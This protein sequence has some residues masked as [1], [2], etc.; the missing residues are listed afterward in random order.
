VGAFPPRRTCCR[1]YPDGGPSRFPFSD[2]QT[3]ARRLVINSVAPNTKR[4][5]STG[6]ASFQSFRVNYGL[7]ETW[8]PPVQDLVLF[9]ASLSLR[10]FSSK[11][12]ELYTAAISFQCKIQNLQDTTK[13]FLVN[14][15]LMGLKRVGKDKKVRLPITINILQG[16]LTK[17][18]AVC[19]NHFE[20]TLFASAFVCAF[21]GFFRVGEI[22]AAGRKDPHIDRVLSI[23]DLQWSHNSDILVIHIRCSKTDQ[24]GQGAFIKLAKQHN[25]MLCPVTTLKHYLA[26]R[27]TGAGPIFQH[28]DRTPLTRHQFSAVLKK[29]LLRLSPELKNFSSHS[30]RLGAASSAAQWGWSVE[31]IKASGRWSSDAYKG[32]VQSI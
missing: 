5:Y 23:Q 28:F 12:V 17:L 1:P 26:I 15:A 16:I 10:N 8:P 30:F 7:P 25:P 21:F 13:H 14:K 18:P 20:T 29:A 24:S 31:S 9:I 11:S 3:E 6:V 2:V 19:L 4:A 27:P 22:T 32:Y